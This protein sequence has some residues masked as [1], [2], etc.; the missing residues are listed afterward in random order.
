MYVLPAN[1]KRRE[2]VIAGL[3]VAIVGIAMIAIAGKASAMYVETPQ[4]TP[5]I[6]EEV[7]AGKQPA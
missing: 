5:G 6:A 2:S 7:V 1:S 4:A 3:T